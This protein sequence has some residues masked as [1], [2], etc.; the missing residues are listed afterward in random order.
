[1]LKLFHSV[2]FCSA[3]VGASVQ[4][5]QKNQVQTYKPGADAIFPVVSN[6]LV[7]DNEVMLIDAQFSP[8]D[9][10]K[11]VERIQATGRAYY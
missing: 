9:G 8:K 1:M 3:I 6:L 4:A 7:A 5:E 2:L 11:L 10:E